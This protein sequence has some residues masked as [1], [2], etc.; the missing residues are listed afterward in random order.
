MKERLAIGLVQADLVWQAP[1]ENRAL[2]GDLLAEGALGLDLA[3][4]PETFTTGFT[5]AADAF[6]EPF[7]G[8]TLEWMADQAARHQLTLAG[9]YLVEEGGRYFNRLVWMPPNGDYQTYDKRHLFSMAGE[10]EVFT[11]G[12]QRKVF[13]CQGWR[14][15]P[16]IC[17]DLRFPVWSRSRQDYDLLFYVANWPEARTRQW[18]RLLTA[19]AIENQAFVAGVN[20][21]GTDGEGYSYAGDSQIYD[22]LGEPMADNEGGET[23][24]R[25]ELSAFQLA[26]LRDKFPVLEDADDFTL[27][28]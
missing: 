12:N 21:F 19:R 5:Q 11:A 9:S 2:L 10:H 8:P 1:A 24:L 20:C 18:S 17:Y 7:E 3:L 22:P 15:C 23:L 16:M 14:C 28:L 4:L 26:R 25:A 6:A 27:K 13:E